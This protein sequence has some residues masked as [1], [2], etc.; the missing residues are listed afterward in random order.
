MSISRRLFLRNAAVASTLLTIKNN[1]IAKAAERTGIKDFY[2]DDFRIGTAISTSTL[3]K[4]DEHMLGLIAREFDAI[5]P[6]N[7]M[8]WEPVRPHDKEWDWAAA[9]KFVEFGQKNNMYIVGHNL[10]WHSQVPKEVFKNEKGGA[11]S[12]ENLTLKMQDHITTLVSRYKGKIHAWDVVNEAV[13]DDG[14]W[15]KSP[16]HNIMGESFI[17]QAFHIANDVDSKAHLIYNDYNTESPAKR[18]FIVDMVK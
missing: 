10:V 14:S 6:E 13:E 2:K 11:I 3:L 8:K 16:W 12:K 1:A 9:D 15:R 5:T 18:N 17:A 4:N 7:C